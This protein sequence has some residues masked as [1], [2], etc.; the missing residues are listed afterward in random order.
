MRPHLDYG[1]VVYQIPD[2]ESK[3]LDTKNVTFHPLMARVESVQYEAACVVSGAWRGSSR[4]KLYNDLGWESLYHRRNLRRLCLFYEVLKNNFPKYLSCNIDTCKPIHSLRLLSRNRLKNWPCRTTKFSR[5]FF[6]SAIKYWNDLEDDIK[7]AT[8]IHIFKNKLLKKIRPKR[9][10]YFGILDKKGTR[11]ITMLR[12]GLS[13]LHKH[14]FDHNFNDTPNAICPAKDGVENTSHFL[15]LCK[16][17]NTIRTALLR[18]VT[19]ILKE[20]INSYPNKKKI[21]ILLYGSE[22]LSDEENRKLLQESITFI[23]KSKRFENCPCQI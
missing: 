14:K 22:T 23:I 13:P 1:D 21:K 10:E 20:N 6:P 18:N 12:M 11:F 4:E 7:C 9:K 8:N 2:K 5:S 19:E 16:T 3:A 15:L 17:Y